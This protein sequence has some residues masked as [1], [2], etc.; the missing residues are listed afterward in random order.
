M[1]KILLVVP[2]IM[3][4]ATIPYCSGMIVPPVSGYVRDDL[5]RLPIPNAEV[6][7]ELST[8]LFSLDGERLRPLIQFQTIS[9]ARGRFRT[10]W[11]FGRYLGYRFSQRKVQTSAEKPGYAT[12]GSRPYYGGWEDQ[13]RHDVWLVHSPL[14]DN[15]VDYINRQE[16]VRKILDLPTP[17]Y[18]L[19]DQFDQGE[20]A[21]YVVDRRDLHRKADLMRFLWQS[22][23]YSYVKSLAKEPLEVQHSR[24][25][26]TRVRSMYKS[27]YP[28]TREKVA[29]FLT[30]SFEGHDVIRL[31]AE[32]KIACD[33][34]I[35]M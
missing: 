27:L 21:K 17:S 31:A 33:D 11:W 30:G 28:E 7:V 12:P 26:C 18:K 8:Y 4:V 19:G 10:Q 23:Q 22:L 3:L 35:K 29:E 6:T 15:E 34:C 32:V 14:S 9:D 20:Y 24:D 25:G 16:A 5:S 2:A 1:K 13:G